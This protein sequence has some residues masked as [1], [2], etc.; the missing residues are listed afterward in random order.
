M[1]KPRLAIL[2]AGPIGLEAA[3]YAARL[4]LPF[5]V[6]DRGGVADN[7]QQWGHVRLFSPFGMNSTPLGRDAVGGDLPDEA[8]Y[9]TGREHRAAYLEPLAAGPLKG[10]V[11]TKTAVVGVA[12]RGFRKDEGVGDPKRAQ[13]PFVLLLKGEKGER[14]DEADVVLDCT[15]TYGHHRW[16]GPGGLPA[17]GERQAEA[18]VRYGLDDVLG[19]H[20]K[21][22]AEKNVLVVGGGYSAATTVTN[23]AKLAERQPGMWV[24]WAAKTSRTQPIRRLMND[25]LRER[26]L[27]AGQANSLATRRDANVEFHHSVHVERVHTDGPDAGF[28]VEAKVG[29]KAVV[30]EVDRVIANIGYTPDVRLNRELQ[31]HQCYASDGPMAL[32]AALLKQGATDCL[33]VAGG[34]PAVLKTTEPG[35][36]VLGAKSFGRSSN[37]LLRAGFEQVRDVFALITGKADL[38]LYKKR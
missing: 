38:D 26:D 12:R 29:A 11:V 4:D 21:L 14:Y 23:L 33:Q 25:P 16:L 10:K 8:A 18:H 36:Y 28:R 22:F 37:F 32:A 13:S 3:L 34:G 31:V 5:A 15:G 30:W 27:L 1:T 35:Y 19:D 6:Y 2:G 24:I 20:A 17:L 9:L 7:V